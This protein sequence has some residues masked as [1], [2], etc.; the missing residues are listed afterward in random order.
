MMDEMASSYFD[1]AAA[2]AKE[3]LVE[4]FGEDAVIGQCVSV[5]EVQE[6]DSTTVWIYSTDSRAYVQVA[7]LNEA[8]NAVR[9]RAADTA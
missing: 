8:V 4:R 1:I 7:L 2:Q 5:V 6:G 3:K 9:E